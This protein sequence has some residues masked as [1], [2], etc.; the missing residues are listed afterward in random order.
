MNILDRIE[1]NFAKTKTAC[2]L[3]ATPDRATKAAEAEVAK[4]NCWHGTDIDCAYLVTFVPTQQK[5]TVVFCFANWLT[6][7]GTGTYMGWFS[8]RNF[9]SI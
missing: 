5:Y 8:Q 2:K 9:F 6:R 7:Y 1:A 3:Y 4:L